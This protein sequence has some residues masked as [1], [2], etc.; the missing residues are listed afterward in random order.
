MRRVRT[1]LRAESGSNLQR[2]RN[3]RRFVPLLFV[4]LPFAACGGSK[5]P[6]ENA[7]RIAG[8]NEPCFQGM[9][10]W[11]DPVGPPIQN[12][13]NLPQCPGKEFR[14]IDWTTVPEGGIGL[15]SPLR[16]F[17]DAGTD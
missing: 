13:Q 4:L 6:P 2:P 14:N 7:Q 16:F 12:T 17:V 15:K 5:H 1:A 10:P 8:P 11:E 9:K 3:V